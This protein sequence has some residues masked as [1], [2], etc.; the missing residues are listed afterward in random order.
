MKDLRNKYGEYV[1]VTGASAG[2]GAEFA[3]QLAANGL[4][5]ALVA[6]RKEKLQALADQ[7][8]AAYGT[9]T[10]VIELD[11][12]GEGAVSE[13]LRRTS[14][15]DVGMV[16]ASAGIATAGPFL[17]TP[18]ADESGLINL[19]LAV[20]MQLA[21]EYGRLFRTRGRGALI[22]LSSAVAFAAVPYMANYSA[23]KAYIA[24]F[25]QALRHEL[26]PSGVDVLVLAPGPTRT[27]GFDSTAGIDFARLPMPAM[28][29]HRVVRTALRGLGRKPLIIPG[30][31][32]RIN[33]FLGKYLTAR[34]IQTAMFGTLVRRALVTEEAS[35]EMTG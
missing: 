4:N 31:L 28:S 8:R 27:E 3:T 11:L 20:P 35:P 5:L 24:N 19:N 34:R 25:G 30:L 26:K 29:A 21:H 17:D 2:I 15:L 10:E 1:V 33:D 6:R 13:L 16:V 23:A 9:T 22:L 18:L 7:L 32:N 12:G 14:H